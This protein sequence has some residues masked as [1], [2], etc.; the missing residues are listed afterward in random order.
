[1]NGSLHRKLCLAIFIFVGLTVKAMGADQFT[2]VLVSAMSPSAGAVLGTDGKRH[3]LY[4]LVITNANLTP[5][6]LQKIEVLDASNLSHA[7]ATYEGN[8]LQSQ[9]RT[10]GKTQVTDANIEFNGARVFLVQLALDQGTSV[11]QR[12]LHR[13]TLLGGAVPV[14]TPQTAVHLQYTVAPIEVK[15]K[16]LII[17][18][19]LEGGRWVALNGCCDAN[20]AHRP[21][22]QTVNGGLYF[23]QRF[24]IDWM[25]LDNQGRLTD[26]GASND[27]Y[28]A[29]GADV[30]A[31]ADGTVVAVADTLEDQ[32][33][34]TLPDV[35]SMSLET[36][37][38]NNVVLDLGGGAFAFYAHLVHKSVTVSVGDHVKRGQVLGKLGNSGNTSAPHLHFHI[39]GSPS[40]LGADGLPYVID[41]FTLEGEIPAA[42]FAASPTLD[43][44]WGENMLQTP[45]PRRDQFPMNCTIIDFSSQEIMKGRAPR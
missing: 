10:L 35:K 31:V 40:V 34:G 1:L 45:S 6:T 22:S 17:G 8:S 23:A 24:A 3:V 4:E 5:A 38:G 25:R 33:P 13:I 26:G 7:V 44:S 20:G 27:S 19:P 16:I 29:Y 32:K 21:S 36:V 41:S 30:L 42:R 37:D 14:P 9:L 39:M 28:A 12:L 2:P 15:M 11:P 43:G 18:P